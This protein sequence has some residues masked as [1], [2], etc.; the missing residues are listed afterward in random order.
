MATTTKEKNTATTEKGEKLGSIA[1]GAG[2][3]G[4]G[5][6]LQQLSDF[7]GTRGH[8]DQPFP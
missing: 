7:P 5:V 6:R 8:K 1:T 4:Q 2:Q 3:E